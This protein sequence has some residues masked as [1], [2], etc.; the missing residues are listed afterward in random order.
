MKPVKAFLYQDHQAHIQVHMNALKDPKIAALMGQNPNAQAI[1]ASAMAH[2][3]EHLAFEYR[4]QMEEMLGMP[5]PTGEE[6]DG[7]PREMEIQISALAAQASNQL[8]QINKTEEA[9]RK[10]QEAA[11]DPV[12]QMQAQELK[13]KEAEIERKKQKDLYDA[14]A[15]ADQI[16]VEEKRIASQEKI[17]GLQVGARL[18]KDQK[19]LELKEMQAGVEIGKA[20]AE[21]LKPKPVEVK[22]SKKE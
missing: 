11:Q 1:G 4:K 6:E 7:I 8:L 19:E 15:K 9:A 17:A 21:T 18:A 20:T 5:L 3:N 22:P 13:I 10:A 2:I 14:A 12:I 16:E